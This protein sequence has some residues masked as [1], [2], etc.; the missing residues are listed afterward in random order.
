MPYIKIGSCNHCGLCCKPP[1]MVENPCIDRGE[2]R[3][4]FYTDMVNDKLYGHCLILGRG[5]R[6]IET[7]KDRF[8]NVITDDQIKWFNKNCIDY[9]T[10]ADIEL[11]HKLLSECSYMFK[12][13]E[14]GR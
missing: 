3:C 6:S 1:I 9:P 10:V 5:D 11:S 14:S 8:G 13:A 4:K 7:V 12:E 2:D